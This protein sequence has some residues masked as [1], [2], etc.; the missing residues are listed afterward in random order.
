MNLKDVSALF[1]SLRPKQWVK[2]FFIFF[3]L[4]FGQKLFSF[5]SNLRTLEAFFLFS[6]AASA[7]YLINDIMDLKKDKFH[8]RTRV[9]PIASGKLS[10]FKAKTAAWVLGVVALA[11]SF[12]LDAPFGS[13]VAL[14][15]MV[16]ILYSKTLKEKVILD[17][18]CIALLFIL[19]VVAGGV[20]AEVELSHWII[21]M[22]G[23]LALFL[24]FNKRRQELKATHENALSHRKVLLDYNVYFIDQMI[25]IITSSIVV[26]YMLYTTDPRTTA[27]F[28]NR[29][30][31]LTI[32]FVYYGIFRYLYLIHKLNVGGDPTRILF[33]DK[34]TQLNLLLWLI[35]CVAV[36]Y[37]PIRWS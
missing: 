17:V 11:F 6:L 35:V 30:I 24:G 22:T 5:P 34:N 31:M 3:P 19:R 20:V 29:N 13:I 15:F 28:G 37:A 32:P 36:I 8:P 7:G 21:V 9:R 2:N 26:A 4:I 18:F 16:N 1:L 33:R 10:V 23:L 12:L 14:Y 27:F 25:A